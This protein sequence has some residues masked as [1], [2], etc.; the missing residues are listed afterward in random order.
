MLAVDSRATGGMYIG[1]QTMKK[2]V[3]INDFL[4]GMSAAANC[5]FL[6]DLTITVIALKERWPEAQLTASTGTGC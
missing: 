2:I 6:Y 3:E 4:L 1:S 5:L